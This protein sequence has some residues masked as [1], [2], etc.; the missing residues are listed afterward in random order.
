[1]K[2]TSLRHEV[3]S[4]LPPLASSGAHRQNLIYLGYQRLI[5]ERLAQ[6]R[7]RWVQRNSIIVPRHV[8]RRDL[9]ADPLEMRPQ[10]VALHARH[11]HIRQQ[12][13]NVSRMR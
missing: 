11:Q 1:M 9:P 7:C 5:G 8:H 6:E 3:D 10:L 12:Q 2:A 4:V 13:I